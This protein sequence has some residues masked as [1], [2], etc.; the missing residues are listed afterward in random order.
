M[1]MLRELSAG[2]HELS[3]QLEIAVDQSRDAWTGGAANT[4]FDSVLTLR[5]QMNALSQELEQ[6]ALDLNAGADIFHPDDGGYYGR[7]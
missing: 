2:L 3:R 1:Y 6:M 5:G 4:F 7:Y